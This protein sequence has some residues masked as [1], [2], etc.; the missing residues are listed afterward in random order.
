MHKYIK[1]KYKKL[2]KSITEYCKHLQFLM[3]VYFIY[4][5]KEF[6][7]RSHIC[8]KSP[9]K[10][11]KL[12]VLSKRNTQLTLPSPK[13]FLILYLIIWQLS[14]LMYKHKFILL[15][16]KLNQPMDITITW[17]VL[18]K[19]LFTHLVSRFGLTKRKTKLT[20]HSPNVSKLNHL[21]LWIKRHRWR[22]KC[23]NSQVAHISEKV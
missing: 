16:E 12:F 18:M 23:Q 3:E 4:P 6:I 19:M 14:I 17:K 1:C 13:S 5:S 22:L 11:P 21:S 9:S 10:S 7:R 15:H 2:N 20:I 8:W